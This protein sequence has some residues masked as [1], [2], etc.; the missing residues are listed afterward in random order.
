MCKLI[1]GVC[2]GWKCRMYAE[3]KIIF[4]CNQHILKM[5]TNLL[6]L[7]H[8]VLVVGIVLQVIMGEK[9]NPVLLMGESI[10]HVLRILLEGK[11]RSIPSLCLLMVGGVLG[12]SLVEK[13]VR[14]YRWVY[15]LKGMEVH[16]ALKAFR[17][18]LPSWRSLKYF[19]FLLD[20]LRFTIAEY[21]YLGLIM[22]IYRA[23]AAS[24]AEPIPENHVVMYQLAVTA[25]TIGKYA[26][27]C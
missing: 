3:G 17:R 6:R 5:L 2:C 13:K 18:S 23:C 20:F 9:L 12:W 21:I 10:V 27:Y 25:S 15:L 4:Y 26:P 19:F 8:S 22:M 24:K 16:Q 7:G 14:L 1:F 11:F